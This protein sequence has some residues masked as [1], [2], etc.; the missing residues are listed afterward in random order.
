MNKVNLENTT[1][2]GV[3]SYFLDYYKM[4]FEKGWFVGQEMKQV[5]HNCYKDLK[6][7]EYD[8]TDAH[9]RIEFTETLCKQSKNRFYGKPLK[10]M[11]WEK[12]LLEVI[13]SFKKSSGIRKYKQILLLI[14]RKNG[15]TTLAASDCNTDLF[16]GSGGQDICCSSNDDAQADLVFQEIDSMREAI[17]PDGKHTH[18]NKKGL[19]NI[20]NRSRVF[21]ISERQKNK[22]GR[23]IT[24]AV[25]DEVHEM[26][27]NTIFM[28]IW[29]SASVVEDPIIIEI[30]TEGIV[31]DGYLDKRLAYARKVLKRE[32]DDESLLPW[33]YTQDNENEIWTDRNSWWKSNPSMGVIKQWEYLEDN[34]EKAR[35]SNEDRAFILCKDFNMKQNK[36]ISWLLHNEIENDESF[37]LEDFRESFYVGGID[38]SETTDLTAASILI[39]KGRKKFFSVMYFIP[40][41]KANSENRTNLERKDYHSLAQKGLVRILPGNEVTYEAITAWYWEL[42][43]KYKLKPFKF[44]YDQWN[45]KGLIKDL[46]YKFGQGVTEKIRMDYSVLSNPMRSLGADFKDHYVNYQ[47]NELTKWNLMNVAVKT[48]NSGLIMPVK[49]QSSTTRIDGAVSMMIAYAVKSMYQADFE[50]LMDMGGD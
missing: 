17:D 14:A 8:P 34:V 45:A 47:N 21:K 20:K 1:I 40:E 5:L 42:Y 24:K 13:Y 28:S 11:K 12:A 37:D 43:E 50:T 27:E 29:Q 48:N 49:V 22:E 33:L 16:I 38:L 46:E 6:H 25:I 4:V 30:T 36:A 31:D 23:N 9:I 41:S 44:G 3:F 18:R 26:R 10:L 7:Y 35:S 2:N 15:K 19:K 32:I 39:Q